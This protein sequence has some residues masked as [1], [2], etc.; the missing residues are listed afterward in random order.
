MNPDV[1]PFWD[2]SWSLGVNIVNKENETLVSAR[3]VAKL[4][5][6]SRPSAEGDILPAEEQGFEKPTS[7]YMY[8][9]SKKSDSGHEESLL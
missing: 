5:R 1:E 2:S 8:S 9:V 6:I 7:G 3:T 4:Y